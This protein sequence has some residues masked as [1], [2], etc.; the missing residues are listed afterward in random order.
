DRFIFLTFTEI[1]LEPLKPL[2][3]LVRKPKLNLSTGVPSQQISNIRLY[4]LV[5]F[6]HTQCASSVRVLPSTM[7]RIPKKS[8]L[9]KPHPALL[10]SG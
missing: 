10:R 6:T 2:K 1:S 3:L 9:I 4:I 5:A 7:K 8:R